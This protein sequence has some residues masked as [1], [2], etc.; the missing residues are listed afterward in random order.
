M[1]KEKDLQRL[2]IKYQQWRK[3][4]I[5]EPHVP[6]E[7]HLKFHIKRTPHIPKERDKKLLYRQE[8]HFQIYLSE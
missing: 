5:K 8:T 6:N 2:I 4:N 1:L 3:T 7:C